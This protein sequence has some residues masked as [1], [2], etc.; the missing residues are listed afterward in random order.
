MT[1]HPLLILLLCCCGCSGGVR[2][3]VSRCR[4]VAIRSSLVVVEVVV[5]GRVVAAFSDK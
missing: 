4:D 5:S 2:F 3:V 1:A